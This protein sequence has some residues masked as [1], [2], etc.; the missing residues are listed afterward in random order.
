MKQV[1][2][3]R[4]PMEKIDYMGGTGD[5]FVLLV[6]TKRY[7]GDPVSPLYE[8]QARQLAKQMRDAGYLVRVIRSGRAEETVEE[9]DF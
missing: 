4:V 3:Q 9:S 7:G 2:W 5:R 1:N 8:S 6:V